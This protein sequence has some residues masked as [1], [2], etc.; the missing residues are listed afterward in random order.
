MYFYCKAITKSY[1]APNTQSAVIKLS[2]G[3]RREVDD[4]LPNEVAPEWVV[5]LE[6]KQP[7]YVLAA[8]V[9]L[10]H[11]TPDSGLDGLRGL[12]LR[13]ATWAAQYGFKQ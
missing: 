5:F 9:L 1:V 7:R 6:N 11:P 4:L 2:E 8:D 12:I 13:L 3:T 10:K